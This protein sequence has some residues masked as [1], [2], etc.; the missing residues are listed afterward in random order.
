MKKLLAWLRKEYELFAHGPMSLF[1]K[2]FVLI[3]MLF[4]LSM[5]GIRCSVSIHSSS[6]E[7]SK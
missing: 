3:V 2:A 7:S 1:E 4:C 5:L 6:Q